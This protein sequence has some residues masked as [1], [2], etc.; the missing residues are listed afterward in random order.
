MDLKLKIKKIYRIYLA[1]KNGMQLYKEENNHLYFIRKDNKKD[2]YLIIMSR[3][4]NEELILEDTLKYFEE[5]SPE[6]YVYDDDSTDNTYKILCKNKNVKVLITNLQWKKQRELEETYS[7]SSLLEEVKKADCKWIMYADADERITDTNIVEKL[8]EIDERYDS[9]KVRLFDSYITEKDKKD[10]QKGQPLL[11][12]RKKFGIEYRDIIMFWR[13]KENICYEGLDKREP[14]NIKNSTIDFKCQHYGK[15]ISIKQWEET[16]KYYYKNFQE[17]YKTKWKNRL[18]KAIHNK[19]DFDT[20]L[21]NWGEELFKNG[22]P[23]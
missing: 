21:Y 20:E 18:G 22:K 14:N 7:R 9:I 8:K 10:Y 16:C 1:K 2:K 13:N 19:S 6:I 5:I 17:P 12:F 15:S 4:R 3:I 11:N 23:I